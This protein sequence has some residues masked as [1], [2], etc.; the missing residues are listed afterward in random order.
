MA[1]LVARPWSVLIRHF[2]S[3]LEGGRQY[4]EAAT[5]VHD[6][7]HFESAT[8][9]QHKLLLRKQGKMTKG[10]VARALPVYNWS[11]TPCLCCQQSSISSRSE[12]HSRL[13]RNLWHL[14]PQDTSA[15]KMDNQSFHGNSLSV[16][17][18]ECHSPS[19]VS[20]TGVARLPWLSLAGVHCAVSWLSH[21]EN[22]GESTDCFICVHIIVRHYSIFI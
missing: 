8:W 14:Y 16:N 4:T 3:I 19:T 13:S 5:V 7:L 21:Q 10:G 15:L 22:L 2:V 17:R 1:V 20:T 11:R 9:T 18:F 12:Y 6:F